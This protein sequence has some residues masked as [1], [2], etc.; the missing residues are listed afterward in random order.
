LKGNQETDQDYSISCDH[1]D[2]PARAGEGDGLVSHF[3]EISTDASKSTMKEL[4]AKHE[5]PREVMAKLPH[6]DV[7]VEKFGSACSA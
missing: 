3:A 7:I 2:A 1:V 6:D 5:W 4:P